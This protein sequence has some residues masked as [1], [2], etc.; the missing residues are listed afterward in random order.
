[1][2]QNTRRVYSIEEYENEYMTEENID[3]DFRLKERD[4]KINYFIEQIKLNE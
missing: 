1:M 2:V 4:E 3:Y